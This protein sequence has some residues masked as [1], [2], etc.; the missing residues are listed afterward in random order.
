MGREDLFGLRNVH[1]NF[2]VAMSV[3][4]SAVPADFI[5]RRAENIQA[6]FVERV[7]LLERVH[8]ANIPHDFFALFGK[9]IILGVAG[10]KF[11]IGHFGVDL[12]FDVDEAVGR[13]RRLP[14]DILFP[15]ERRIVAADLM[16]AVVIGTHFFP[17]SRRGIFAASRKRKKARCRLLPCGAGRVVVRPRGDVL[18]SCL[19]FFSFR[20]AVCEVG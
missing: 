5:D 16:I 19:H 2:A 6:A 8:V 15:R 9:R 1:R 11:K 18:R 3:E 13:L 20:S 4:K 12:T 10:G 14:R 17:V 7:F